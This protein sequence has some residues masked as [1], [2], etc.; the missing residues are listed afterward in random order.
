MQHENGVSQLLVFTHNTKLTSY[1]EIFSEVWK[2]DFHICD[3][4]ISVIF[5]LFV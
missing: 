2:P 5:T 3:L 1:S 4:I